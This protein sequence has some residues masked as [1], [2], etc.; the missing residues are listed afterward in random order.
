MMIKRTLYFKFWLDKGPLCGPLIT[1]IL[2]FV[3]PFPWVLSQGGS[4]ACTLAGLCAVILK[5][6]VWCYTY[7]FHQCMIGG[8]HCVWVCTEGLS[9]GHLTL[10]VSQ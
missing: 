2:D 9:S 10:F 5:G 4:L 7:L 8:V 3:R 6:N 1:L